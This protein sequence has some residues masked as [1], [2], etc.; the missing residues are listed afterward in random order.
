MHRNSTAKLNNIL[1][2]DMFHYFSMLDVRIEIE[3]KH[4]YDTHIKLGQQ[5]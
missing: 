3:R 4:K 5:F 2:R 1:N